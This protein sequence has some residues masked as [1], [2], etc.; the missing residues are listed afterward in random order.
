MGTQARKLDP[1][2]PT[3]HC[4][5]SWGKE[6]NWESCFIFPKGQYHRRATNIEYKPR[7]EISLVLALSWGAEA[8]SA[9]KRRLK[10]PSLNQLGDI[11]WGFW[12]FLQRQTVWAQVPAALLLSCATMGKSLNPSVPLFVICKTVIIMQ[13]P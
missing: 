3:A 2:G 12:Y 6:W 5:W 10:F 9:R 4:A 13:P 1:L 8:L 7:A 11:A